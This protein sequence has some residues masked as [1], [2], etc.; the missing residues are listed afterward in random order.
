MGTSIYLDSGMPHV[1]NSGIKKTF[2]LVMFP[3]LQSRIV[4]ISETHEG[5]QVDRE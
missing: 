3:L 5:R 4:W 1:V 2:Y